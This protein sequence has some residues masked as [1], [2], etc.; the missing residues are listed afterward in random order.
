[1]NKKNV[2]DIQFDHHT[3]EFVADPYKIYAELH[4][5]C[6]VAHTSAHD[7]FWLL[8]RYLD[9]RKALLAPQ[10]FSSAQPGTVA[11]PHTYR[12]DN[13]PL[14]PIEADP[15]AHTNYRRNVARLFARRQVETIAADVRAIARSCIAEFPTS[16]PCEV[17]TAYA[18]PLFSSTLALF[19]QLP[20]EDTTLW[21]QWAEAIFGGRVT[22]PDG[23][24]Q[25]RS[26]LLAYVDQILDD[27]R[28]NPRDD[29]FTALLHVEHDGERLS[30][31][32]LRGY[33]M[34]ILLAGREATIDGICNSL[35]LLAQEPDMRARLRAEPA[36]MDSA[37]EE[38]LRYLSPIQLLG[39]IATRDVDIDEQHIQQGASVAMVFAAA[40][41][42][43]GQFQDADKCLLDR[44]PNPHL[45]FGAGPH[46]CIG[47]HLA[48]LG[49]RVALQELLAH[50]EDFHLS[51]DDP[52]QRKMNGDAYGFLRLPIAF[53]QTAVDEAG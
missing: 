53:Q 48:R 38:F 28:H 5:E 49:M 4:S 26:D 16:V 3:H 24:V 30:D 18:E 52:P 13:I 2:Q 27:R 10:V 37:V 21:K 23:A 40:N 36:L 45:A 25:A 9:V 42:D 12:G 22:D 51:T 50:F 6:P 20:V 39:R 46:T 35:W 1:V 43:E 8:T 29:V 33:G 17:V 15:P 31:D 41:R 32:E 11:I 44:S 19:L 47:A 7:G 34:E 14:L